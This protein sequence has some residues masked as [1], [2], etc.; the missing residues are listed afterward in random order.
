MTYTMTKLVSDK[1]VKRGDL[2]RVAIEN[3]V[4]V[5]ASTIA[6]GSTIQ[7]NCAP[8]STA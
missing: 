8:T 5:E 7:P 4:V 2:F 3:L 1:T 6:A